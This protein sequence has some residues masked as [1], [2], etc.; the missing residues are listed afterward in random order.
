MSFISKYSF[1]QRWIHR[2]RAA[3]QELLISSSHTALWTGHV[4]ARKQTEGKNV[5]V[6]TYMQDE[7]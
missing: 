4:P 2:T 1:S 3:A 6:G 5:S 7:N